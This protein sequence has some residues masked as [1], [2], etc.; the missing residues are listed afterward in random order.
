MLTPGSSSSDRSSASL[1]GVGFRFTV[2]LSELQ[3]NRN[4]LVRSMG[5]EVEDQKIQ[6]LWL[7]SGEVGAGSLG[8]ADVNC[9]TKDGQTTR[10]CRRGPGAAFNIL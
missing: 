10:A 7:P 1:G 8:L 3:I 6:E 9:Y 2:E 4:F 5:K